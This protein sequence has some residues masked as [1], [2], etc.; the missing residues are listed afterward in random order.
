MFVIVIACALT[1]ALGIALGLRSGHAARRDLV[2]QNERFSR[3]VFRFTME[4]DDARQIQESTERQMREAWDEWA[5][6][7]LAKREVERENATLRETCDNLNEQVSDYATRCTLLQID[8]ETWKA[9]AVRSVARE[10]ATLKLNLE[11]RRKLNSANAEVERLT[12]RRNE[13]GE[14]VPRD[15]HEDREDSLVVKFDS[16]QIGEKTTCHDVTL[17]LHGNASE[18]L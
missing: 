9:G 11:L 5:K 16:L 13:R 15:T 4:L 8:L 17:K 3:L 10:L 12:P 18:A 1:G 7:L 14:F 6:E 2:A